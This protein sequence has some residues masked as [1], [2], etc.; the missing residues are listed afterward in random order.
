MSVTEI[1]VCA[2]GPGLLE[3]RLKLASQVA[4]AFKSRVEVVFFREAQNPP[5]IPLYEAGFNSSPRHDLARSAWDEE[6]DRVAHAKETFDRCVKSGHTALAGISEAA[7]TPAASWSEVMGSAADLFPS[8][9]RGCDLVVAGGPGGDASSSTLDDEISAMALLASGRLTLLA[10]RP[11]HLPDNLFRS[12]LIAW[13]DSAAASRTLA[14]AMPL[15]AAAQEVRLFVG[16]TS[17]ESAVRCNDI[18]SYLR[19]KGVHP[20]VERSVPALHTIRET[21]VQQAQ[22]L[23]VSL[24]VMGAYKHSRTREILLGGT[25]RHVIQHAGCAVLMAD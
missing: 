4:R 2:N 21:L 10:P 13:D 25:T 7:G 18:L 1:L 17:P 19:R 11:G 14:Q 9:A 15:V 5:A 6:A 23:G 12:V 22:A 20:T 3:S 24:I 16:E 8:R